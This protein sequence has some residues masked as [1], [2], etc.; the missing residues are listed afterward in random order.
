MHRSYCFIIHPPA[1]VQT[2]RSALHEAARWGHVDV[3]KVLLEA[4]ADIQAR[5]KVEKLTS[6]QHIYFIGILKHQL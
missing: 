1:L 2:E 6:Y 3:V 4:G 5:D